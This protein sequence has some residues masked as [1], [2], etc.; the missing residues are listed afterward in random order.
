MQK[1][2]TVNDAKVVRCL[3][4]VGHQVK[5]KGLN[6]M[7][8]VEYRVERYNGY[9]TEKFV[10]QTLI[11][12]KHMHVHEEVAT[13]TEDEYEQLNKP[14]VDLALL[15][16]QF[17]YRYETKHNPNEVVIGGTYR[18][19]KGKYVKVIAVSKNSENPSDICVVY[20]CNNGIYHRPLD[21][22]LSEV[23]HKKYPDVT[24]KCRFEFV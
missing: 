12:D 16:Q 1:Q 10:N 22:F 5:Q 15:E 2:V 18:H 6:N 24:Q 20:Q 9:K 13:I 3:W 17:L 7:D 23:D 11:E 4:H 21:M 8:E 19:F 14:N